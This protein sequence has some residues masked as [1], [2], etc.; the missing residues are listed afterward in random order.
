MVQ[1]LHAMGTFHRHE[2]VLRHAV[3]APNAA[4][5]CCHPGATVYLVSDPVLH[6][7]APVPR[8]LWPMDVVMR[9]HA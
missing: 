4:W 3:A 8:V 2:L 5:L 9:M 1:W 6:L 7:S